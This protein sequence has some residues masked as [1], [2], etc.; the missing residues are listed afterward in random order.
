MFMAMSPDS[1]LTSKDWNPGRRN[2]D[3][4]AAKTAANSRFFA[5]VFGLITRG[6]GGPMYLGYATA[7]QRP[8]LFGVLGSLALR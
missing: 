5:T 3:E 7:R 4:L 8:L 1:P 6:I 2:R